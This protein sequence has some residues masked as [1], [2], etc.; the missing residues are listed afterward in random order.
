MNQMSMAVSNGKTPRKGR[1]V[2]GMKLRL[3]RWCPGGAW[4]PRLGGTSG[5]STAVTRV[6]YQDY[7]N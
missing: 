6:W 7:D 3:T 5:E 2:H 1:P 4:G